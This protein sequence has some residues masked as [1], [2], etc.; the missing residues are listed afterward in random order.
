MTAPAGLPSRGSRGT[1][2]SMDC[3]FCRIVRGELPSLMIHQDEWTV[4][5][6][7]TGPVNRGHALVVPR[8]HAPSLHDLPA[9]VVAPL[10]RT[11]GLVSA[12]ALRALGAAGFNLFLND[13]VVAG[14]VVPHVHFHILPRYPGDGLEFRRLPRTFD[15]GE[16]ADIRRLIAGAIL[17]GS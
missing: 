2:V 17:P 12:A 16:M 13:G 1:E 9:E 10:M 8:R 6:L 11:V 3:I 5:F 4:S 15:A 14:Q 7:D